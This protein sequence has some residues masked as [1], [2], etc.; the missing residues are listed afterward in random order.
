MDFWRFV[1]R[2]VFYY[3]RTNVGVLLAV[4]V[5]SSVLIGALV[6]GDSVR[7]SLGRMVMTRLGAIQSA[8]VGGDRFF[9]SELALEIA[10]ELEADVAP[11]LQLRGLTANSD[12][13]KRA[14]RVEVLGVDERFFEIG[15]GVNPF[16]GDW[17]DGVVLSEA[18]A[19]RLGAKVGDEVLLRIAKPGLMPRD[20]PLGAESDLSV[21]FRLAVKAIAVD[22]EFGRFS[23]QANQ[24]APLNVFVNLKW[25]GEKIG[26]AGLANMLLTG[27]P[28][29][30][31]NAALQKRW[32]I[33]DAGLEFNRIE[34]QGVLE[35]RSRRVFIDDSIGAAA[36]SDEGA[37]GLLTYFVNEIRR[38][39]KAAPYS[40]VTAIEPWAG[41]VFAGE[42]KDD[43]IL[44]NQWLADDIGAQVGDEITIKY[45]VLAEMRR[46]KEVTG[47]FIVRDIVSMEE[48][49][50]SEMMPQFPG[51]ANMD[52]CRDWEPGIP[53]EL[54]RI[55]DKD[56]EY[57]DKYRGTPKAFVTLSA[58]QKMWG[59]RY[60]KL[61]AVRWYYPFSE[62]D[63]NDAAKRLMSKIKPGP[64]GLFF[65]SVREMAVAAGRGTTDFGQLFLGFSM[66]LIAAAII[67]T[68]LLFV[69]GIENRS[70]EIGMLLAVGYRPGIV[71]RLFLAEGAMIS[72]IG[73]AIGAGAAVVYTKLIIYGMTTIWRQAVSGSVI[74]FYA[75]GSTIVSGAAG[76]IAVSLFAIW[77]SLRKQ[78]KRPAREL[79]VSDFEGQYLSSRKGT[80]GRGGF[81]LAAAGFIG[82]MV[83][84][85]VMGRG[86]SIVGAFFGAGALLLIG[87]VG[88]SLGL[89]RRTGAGRAKAVDSVFSL[90]LRNTVRRRGRSLAVI[91]LLACGSFMVIAV[92]A[93]RHGPEEIE[94][95]DSGT[96]GFALFGES[97][98]GVLH[99]L[100]SR[101]GM[102]AVGLDE[103]KL[104]GAKIVQMR[105]R[106]GDDASC[107]NLNRAQRPRLIGVNNQEF[108]NRGAFRFIDWLDGFEYYGWELLDIGLD[109]VISAIGD[110]ATVR[111]A[112]GKSVGDTID[113]VDNK[114]R[115]F[116]VRLVGKIKNSILQGSLIIA[117]NEFIERF[118]SEEGYRM[119]LVDAEADKMEEVMS[120]LSSGLRD[121]GMEVTPAAERL[122]EFSMVEHTYLSIFL[123]LGG[124]GLVLGSAGLGMVVLRNILERRGELAMLRAVG[125]E[126]RT[127]KRMVLYEHGWLLI[128]G[129]ACG[130]V[131][132]LVAVGP[133]LKEPGAKVPYFGLLIT[134]IL[135]AVSGILWIFAA[136]Y[137]ALR[138]KLLDALRNE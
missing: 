21:A 40:M 12:G 50:D 7:Y 29:E 103:A 64:M 114:G 130:V 32:Q 107:F 42:L 55:R 104:E 123:M 26:Q 131:T 111:W 46:L 117:E 84:L 87:C 108:A 132:A 86:D 71:K 36:A 90:A 37:V 113:Y 39:D 77:L 68:G 56:E 115:A 106:D 101:A 9:R 51:L 95:R 122:A 89:L 72:V 25:L 6:V 70:E 126:K 133:V 23:L 15:E 47:K 121:F 74:S 118:G 27:G 57:W 128:C 18:V 83:L 82:A 31:A 134:V 124:L 69:F 38:G 120:V 127:L 43:E 52:N 22:D 98:I 80:K 44:I 8:L 129:L 17:A 16:K 73:T 135:I 67:L 4:V 78:V 109:N 60:G 136:T 45:F 58:G 24:V 54:D 3:W 102:E 110:E 14:N 119:F 138:G 125:F 137:F 19:G 35:V 13:T 20:V 105:V 30:K 100:N 33:A 59:N 28:V 116:K 112:L 91:V 5:S 63:E 88:L 65:V 79:L 99:D 94:K 11:V 85:F 53:I 1:K 93:N 2:S 48:S 34:E 61:T 75:K 92:G 10:E 62:I 97:A 41:S 81:V 76:A 49:G 66:F 96:G